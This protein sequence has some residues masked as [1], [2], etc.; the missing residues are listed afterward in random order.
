MS[1]AE[2][3]KSVEKYNDAIGNRNPDFPACGAVPLRPV[4]TVLRSRGRTIRSGD[5]DAVCLPSAVCRLLSY[6]SYLWPMSN[7]T[8]LVGT[9][10]L[11]EWGG[12]GGDV[13][14]SDVLE[15]CFLSHGS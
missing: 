10:L 5:L 7:S 14:G 3:I 11:H 2:S 1:E 15:F 13:E 9:E 6:N 12:G 4:G 8:V